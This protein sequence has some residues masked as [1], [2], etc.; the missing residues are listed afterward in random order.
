MIPKRRDKWPDILVTIKG[1]AEADRLEIFERRDQN[2]VLAYKDHFGVIHN[3]TGDDITIED[4][5]LSGLLRVDTINEFTL[6]SGVTI[7]GVLI[8]DGIVVYSNESCITAFATGGQASATQLTAQLNNVTTVL[9]DGDS[10]KLM[11]AVA[12]MSV[13]VKNNGVADLAVFPI[14]GGFINDLAVNLSV[15][16]APGETYIFTAFDS[17]GCG[18]NLTWE[19]YAAI[20]SIAAAPAGSAYTLGLAANFTSLSGGTFTV[21]NPGLID[22]TGDVTAT[23]NVNPAN[24]TFGTGSFIVGPTAGETAAVLALYNQLAALVAT[25]PIDL[26][27]GNIGDSNIGYGLGVFVPGVYKST[28]A[29]SVV[30]GKTIT[31]SGEGDYV[32]NIANALTTG[33]NVNIVLTNGAVASRVFF[34]VSTVLA[35]QAFT[36]GATNTLKG[37]FIVGNGAGNIVIGATNSIEGRLLTTATQPIVID[38]TASGLYLPIA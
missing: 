10:V 16:I 20:E 8:K 2:Y 34:V 9:S 31:L 11:A 1:D 5:I 38:G 23:S 3:L 12:G 7:E 21:S 4:L 35:G 24:T 37:N 33:A 27:T 29:V 14:L 18:G 22:P 6:G 13:L 32:F 15:T 17:T 19:T 28:A 25:D 30:A 26:S 36:S